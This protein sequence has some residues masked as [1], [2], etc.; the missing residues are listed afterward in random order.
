M[1]NL[2]AEA[3]EVFS[4]VIRMDKLNYELLETLTVTMEWIRDYAMK[5]NIPLPS[6]HSTYFSLLAKAQQ[7]ID[8]LNTSNVKTVQFRKIS[9]ESY[10][11]T[12]IRRKKTGWDSDG[13]ET[14]PKKSICSL[15]YASVNL[16]ISDGNG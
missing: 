16:S 12:V 7:L 13:E 4:K 6:P 9:D 11:D 14:E 10:H 15:S 3:N 5:K 2:L 1:N 8:E